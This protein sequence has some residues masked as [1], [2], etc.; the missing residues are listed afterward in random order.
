MKSRRGILLL[1][2]MVA[3][4]VITGGLLFVMRVYSTAKYAL[5][6]SRD[7]FKHSLLLEEKIFDFE[8]KGAIE[9]DKENGRFPD[10][11]DYFWE[12]EADALSLQGQEL[13]DLCSV[14]LDV[15]YR[16]DSSQSSGA[17]EKYY[18]YTYLNKKK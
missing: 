6:R 4:V 13:G 16:K 17:P 15:F 12:V 7:I 2:V 10:L 14:K 18:L 8:E 3:I 9:E 11:K 5:D 1:E